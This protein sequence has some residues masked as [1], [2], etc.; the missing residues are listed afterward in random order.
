[1]PTRDS[2]V[3]VIFGASGDL[4]ARK[5]VPALF[6]LYVRGRLPQGVR[7]IG[8]SR[9]EL[10]DDDYRA[11]LREWA[12]EHASGFDAG[13]WDEFASGIFYYAGDATE[14]E[15]YPGLTE[16]LKEV[17]KGFA[18]PDGLPNL[19]FYL[20][21]SPNLYKPIIEQ[22]GGSGLVSEGK[23]WC[24]IDRDSASWQRI[25][26]EK[27]FGTDL[28]SAE[29]LNRALGRVFEEEDTFRID[30]YLG[31]DLVQDILVVRFANAIFEPIWNRQYVDHVQVT[32]AESIGV[33]SR[34]G[35]FYDRA[36]AIR[37][38]IQSHLLQVL[39]LVA[40]EP[41]T[42]YEATAIMREKINLLRSAVAP[43]LEEAP[44]AA[45]IGRYGAGPGG[46]AYVEEQGVDPSLNTE[47]FGAIRFEFDN[48]RW[49]GVP[50]YVRSGKRMARKLTEVVVQFRRPPTNLFRNIDGQCVECESNRL[51]MGIAP[52][53]GIVLELQGKVPGERFRIGTAGLEL[54]YRERFGGEPVEAYGP[55]LLDAIRGDRTLYK[56]RE[57]V[58][59]AWRI[60]EPFLESDR[61]RDRIEEYE[62]GSWGPSG[63]DEL[64]RIDGR[65]WHNPE[66]GA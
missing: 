53:E 34:A 58:E 50:F 3:I 37:D 44:S 56:H 7:L 10:S 26:V 28:A 42:E 31:K 64:I 38:M 43:S 61:L 57:E 29:S 40:I 39:A 63:S 13:K 15:M 60:V 41:P 33:G 16:R 22:I 17:G 9:T 65:S 18:G 47:T 12:S 46:P 49:A 2:C 1:M 23:R 14:H 30:H 59:G 32:A 8:V 11:K 66:T 21:V 20:A 55:L 45:S 52:R 6:E 19:L 54:D 51:V 24:S 4:T 48:W 5:L 27:P 35:T 25:I 62:P 36:G